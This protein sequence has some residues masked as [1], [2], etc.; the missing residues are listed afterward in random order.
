MAR[1]K[2]GSDQGEREALEVAAQ[3]WQVHVGSEGAYG[4]SSGGAP[5][6]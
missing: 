1:A 2:A 6:D 5:S 4:E 3:Q